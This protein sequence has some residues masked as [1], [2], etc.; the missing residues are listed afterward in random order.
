[1]HIFLDEAGVF[2]RS[3]KKSW[4]VSCVGALAI[5]GDQLGEILQGF[6]HLKKTWGKKDGEIKGRELN[7]EQ[8]AAVIRFLNNFEVLFE[9]APIDMQR[10]RVE[11]IHNHKVQQAE[12]FVAT[13]TPSH[14]PTLI[15]HFN[16][17]RDDLLKLSIPLYVQGRVS[18][19]LIGNFLD[20]AV[21]YYLQ[22]KPSELGCFSWRIDAKNHFRT[23]YEI[24]WEKIIRPG[25]QDRSG[26]KPLDFFP[27]LDY[28]PFSKFIKPIVRIPEQGKNTTGEPKSYSTIDLDQLMNEDFSYSQSENDLGIQLADIL[29]T[30]ARRAMNGTLGMEGWG[31]IGTLMVQGRRGES[32]VPMVVL[33]PSARERPAAKYAPYLSFL[34]RLGLQAKPMLTPKYSSFIDRMLSKINTQKYQSKGKA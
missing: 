19:P 28:R 21:P 25:L 26:K 9:V 1:M 2:C 6:S 17:I 29:V 13:L 8:A 12:N 5:P 15:R 34:P 22:R 14:S 32:V 3:E 11:D 18:I 23:P 27:H 24:L 7:E 30:T 16:G 10:E 20:K 31:E 4:A 33:S